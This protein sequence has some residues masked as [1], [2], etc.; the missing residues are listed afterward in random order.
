[1]IISFSLYTPA[2]TFS[3][4]H[5]GFDIVIYFN[6]PNIKKGLVKD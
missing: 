4:Y 5:Y 6:I 2:P 3:K 1:M